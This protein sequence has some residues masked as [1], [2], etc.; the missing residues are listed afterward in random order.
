MVTPLKPDALRRVCQ[1][2]GLAFTGTEELPRRE[3]VVAQGRAV[4]AITFGVG[5]RG[6]GFNLFVLGPPG[7]GKTTAIKRFLAREASKLATP[8]DW[9]Y[10]NN[11][12]DPQ[13][14][15]ALRLPP[16]L[17]RVLQADCER[18]LAERKGGVPTAFEAEAY[19]QQRRASLEELEKQTRRER[20]ASPRA[21]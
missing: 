9:C 11:F 19:E 18:L 12:A 16:G 4:E 8:P 21:G 13:R 3:E 15:R 5:M 2:E 17:A 20:E 10:V 14:P 1:P 6:A 7:T